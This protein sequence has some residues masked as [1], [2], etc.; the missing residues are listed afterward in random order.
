M[1][2]YICQI[3]VVPLPYY[4]PPFIEE[5]ELYSETGEVEDLE[6]LFGGFPNSPLDNLMKKYGIPYVNSYRI[7]KKTVAEP[8]HKM[9][10]KPYSSEYGYWID[11]CGEMLPVPRLGHCLVNDNG[12]RAGWIAII[13]GNQD[14]LSFRFRKS[15]V[16]KKALIQL[17]KVMRQSCY[18]S[19]LCTSCTFD[20]GEKDDYGRTSFSNKRD[21]TEAIKKV[22]KEVTS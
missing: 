16:T 5:V 3:E 20:M 19:Y 17:L 1:K 15:R 14:E 4:E 12:Y 18:N 10:I 2:K 11:D 7:I 22:I 6:R 8:V 9:V 21:A 13:T